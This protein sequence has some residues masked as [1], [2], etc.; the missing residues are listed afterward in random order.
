LVTGTRFSLRGTL[1]KL[2]WRDIPESRVKPFLI[3]DTLQEFANAGER[4]V[5]IAIFVAVNLLLFQGFH[6]R[7]ASRVG[8]GRQLHRMTT[9]PIPLLKSSTHTIR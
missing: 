6:E 1:L 2:G 3:I 7:F 5:E 8:E 4:L 9:M